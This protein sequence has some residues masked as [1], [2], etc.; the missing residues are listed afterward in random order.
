MMLKLVTFQSIGKAPAI[1]NNAS[2]IWQC[3][4]DSKK[5]EGAH[6]T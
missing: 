6:W 2:E 1:D 5:D 4:L 3:Q